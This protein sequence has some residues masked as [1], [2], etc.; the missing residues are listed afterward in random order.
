MVVTALLQHGVAVPKQ[1]EVI[2][3]LHPESAVQLYPTP[4]AYHWPMKQVV[5]RITS[6]VEK[7]FAN[8]TLAVG[9]EAI[10]AELSKD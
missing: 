3:L 7:Y 9:G 4:P 5:R 6:A 10:T 2:A 8:G 1:A